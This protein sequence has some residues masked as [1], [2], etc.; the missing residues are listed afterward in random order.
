[1]KPFPHT[2]DLIATARRI[3]WFRPA[4]DSLD[5]PIELLTYAMAYASPADM[6]TLLL[7]VGRE[8]LAEAINA[9]L[10][11]IVDQRS[12]AYWNL[13]LGQAPAPLPRRKIPGV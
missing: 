10:P 6:N 5:S 3:I 13:M 2:P 9:Q 1:M 7:H 11:G 8:G 12:W 4:D